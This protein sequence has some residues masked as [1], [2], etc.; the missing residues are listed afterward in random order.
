MDRFLRPAS[1]A[2]A[3]ALALAIAPASAVG[4]PA[5]GEGST[6]QSHIVAPGDPGS[7][8]YQEDVPTAAG[9]RPVTTLHPGSGTPQAA[10]SLPAPVVRKLDAK[11]TVGRQTV[12][13]AQAATPPAPKHHVVLL[14]ATTAAT[15]SLLASA[16]LGS[17]GG[18]GALLPIVLILSLLVA[19]LLTIRRRMR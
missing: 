19:L 12:A 16:L 2:L 13:L 4:Q 6:G 5:A 11:G 7:A 10:V 3:A 17:G 15:A 1:L 9:S 8:Q 14:R 18:A